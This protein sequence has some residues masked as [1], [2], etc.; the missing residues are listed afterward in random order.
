LARD[1]DFDLRKFVSQNVHRFGKPIHLLAGKKSESEGTPTLKVVIDEF[2][3]RSGLEIRSAHSI[4]NLAMAVSM[5]ASTR[6]VTLLPA[7]AVSSR[8]GNQ[9]AALRRPADH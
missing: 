8:L 3:S 5:V 4:D 7:Y 2:M 1:R 9:P 6:G